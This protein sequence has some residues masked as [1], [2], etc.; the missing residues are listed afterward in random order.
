MVAPSGSPN[1]YTSCAISI[2]LGWINIMELL[3]YVFPRLLK[4]SLLSSH[5]LGNK[6]EDVRVILLKNT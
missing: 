2:K 6:N 3:K 5:H 4:G 1:F